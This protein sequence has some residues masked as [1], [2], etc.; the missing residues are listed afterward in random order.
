[1]GLKCVKMCQNVSKWVE[2]DLK[3]AICVKMGQNVLKYYKNGSKWLKLSQNES[4]I[5]Q[6]WVKMGFDGENAIF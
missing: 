6:K 5:H 3:I 1:M 4:K 2:M